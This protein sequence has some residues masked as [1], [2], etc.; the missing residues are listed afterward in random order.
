MLLKFVVFI[1]GAIL[2][3][4]E[5]VGSRVLA[6]YFG[7][8]IF[9][10]GSL[11]SI[12]LA[13]LSLGYYLG[14]ILADWKPTLRA[15]ALLI[16]IPGII[17]FLLPFVYPTINS[18]IVRLDFGPRL[19]PL[20]AT[21]IL[22]FIPSVFL[23][24]LSPYAIKL[25]ASNLSTLGNTAGVLYAISTCGSIVGTLLTA[26][27][28]IPVMGVKNIVHTLGGMLILLSL[29]LIAFEVIKQLRARKGVT[30]ALFL[31]FL[32][33]LFPSQLFAERP[34]IIYEKDS[35]YHH[36]IIVDEGDSRFMRF[37]NTKQSGMYLNDPYKTRLAYTDY[38]HLG[39]LFYPT[40][41]KE[42]LFVGLG[43]GSTP[44]QF[45]RNYPK[46]KIDVAEI[47]PEVIRLAKEFFYM[48]EDDRLKI[49]PQDGRLFIA[50]AKKKYDIA[51]LDAYY[52]DALPFHLTTVE[53]YDELKKRLASNA[54]VVSNV[55]G[56]LTGQRSHLFRA[57][58][59]TLQ[60][61][62][63]QTYVFPIGRREM[64][65]E[66]PGVPVND[67]GFRNIIIVATRASERVSKEAVLQKAQELAGQKIIDQA[68]FDA[69]R[70][71]IQ[72]D[73][74]IDDAPLLTDD[75]APVDSLLHF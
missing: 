61:A 42:T 37:D 73:L 30:V 14:G 47:D 10:W 13:G 49:F 48:K 19:N 33:C 22:F 54:V 6:P 65:Q 59:K 11:I 64:V 28:L 34:K 60:K 5:I 69:A 55:I 75:Y 16:L 62:F 58:L 25:A 26:F 63:P 32:F 72:G 45:H 2:M 51:I 44:K 17:T 27:F 38:L 21:T 53:F 4:L 7:N 52:S 40:T 68:V 56:A 50:K 66:R 36:I 71:Y 3:A 1:G 29:F 24:A 43:G 35:L 12:F 41:A 46:M 8:S 70:T 57:M 18:I 23:G 15:M 67:P 74:N 31:G 39:V 9:V 20:L